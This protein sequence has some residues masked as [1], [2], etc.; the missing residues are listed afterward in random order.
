M[1]GFFWIVVNGV[2][3]VLGF[4]TGARGGRLVRDG[5]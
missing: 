3:F 4:E 1:A 2:S 5:I